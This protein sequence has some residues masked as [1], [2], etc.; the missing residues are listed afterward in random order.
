[1]KDW[2]NSWHACIEGG[3]KYFYLNKS[4]RKLIRLIQII[5][6][7][8]IV[9]TILLNVIKNNCVKIPENFGF[10]VKSDQ[11]VY[12]LTYKRILDCFG[13]LIAYMVQYLQV[14]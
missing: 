7:S 8:F 10:F 13:N 6:M 2:I 4:G 14:A 3:Y 9:Y 11:M 5:L 12:K 1:M